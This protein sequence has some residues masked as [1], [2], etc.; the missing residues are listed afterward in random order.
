MKGLN[1][2]IQTWDGLLALVV[3]GI[4]EGAH[5]DFKRDAYS[6]PRKPPKNQEEDREELRRDAAS[7]ANNEGGVLLIGV[8]EKT[9]RAGSVPGIERP[10][11]Q[12]NFVRDVLSRFI[13][14]PLTSLRVR[15]IFDPQDST[16][17]VVVVQLGQAEPG[18]PHAVQSKSDG[19]LDF[20]IRTD[21][22]KR[23]M[24]YLQVRAN[25]RIGD[26][27]ITQQSVDA[28]ALSEIHKIG[29]TLREARDDDK[30]SLELL[31]ELRFYVAERRYGDQVQAE[32][33]EA[34][35]E[36]VDYPRAGISAQV[37]QTAVDI[38][39]TALPYF[40]R[41]ALSPRKVTKEER[42]LLQ[43]AES[44][45]HALAYDGAKYLK[46]LRII[47][48]GARLMSR[49]LRISHL[50][51]LD[52]LKKTLLDQFKI[53]RE[54]AEERDLHDAVQVLDYLR[55]YAFEKPEGPYVQE[56]EGLQ[57]AIFGRGSPDAQPLSKKSS[58]R[59]KSSTAS[60]PSRASRPRSK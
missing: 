30:R 33:M 4:T 52:D 51:R 7:F 9:G 2:Y 21:K 3:D 53:V 13:E 26:T 44:Y 49:L 45:G 6:D 14:P 31:E 34:V 41:H 29:Y 23:R 35:G 5:L 32:V 18:L 22:S 55:D 8:E 42:H 39:Q 12:E 36:A 38:I 48:I 16:R 40:H 43:L 54:I 28:L 59:K 20:W 58:S 25:F 11:E 27:T 17:G 50:N 1:D 24:M 10:L 56:P 57:W 60:R 47:S 19:P 46:D 15:T 37:A